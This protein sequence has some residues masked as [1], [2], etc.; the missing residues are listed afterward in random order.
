MASMWYSERGVRMA[1]FEI[2]GMDEL[3]RSLEA[4]EELPGEVADDVLNEQAD[5]LIREIKRVGNSMGVRDTGA[6]LDSLKKSKVGRYSGGAFYIDVKF[7]G[8]RRG[9][10]RNAEVAF[11]NNYGK[12]NQPARPFVD[13]GAESADANMFRAANDAVDKYLKK[14]GF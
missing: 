3:L 11:I 1:H 4:L 7:D 12:T 8:K 14:K 6:T 13:V 9:N 5:I 2:T 10:T